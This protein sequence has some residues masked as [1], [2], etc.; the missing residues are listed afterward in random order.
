ME[1]QVHR[2]N[3]ADS[4]RLIEQMVALLM[5]LKNNLHKIILGLEKLT[6]KTVGE[7]GGGLDLIKKMEERM[8]ERTSTA[9]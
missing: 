9:A 2:C 6:L 3:W 8:G 4:P 5:D 7:D 1:V